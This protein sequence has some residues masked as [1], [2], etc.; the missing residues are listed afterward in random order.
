MILYLFLVSSRVHHDKNW[1]RPKNRSAHVKTTRLD[2]TVVDRVLSA[3]HHKVAK[4]ESRL[5]Q[6]TKEL[7]KEREENRTL[8]LIQHRQEKKLEQVIGEEAELP[9]L[10]VKHTAEVK[11]L[12]ERVRKLQDTSYHKDERL[13]E[14]DKVILKLKDRCKYYKELCEKEELTEKAQLEK[15]LLK[16]EDNLKKRD[17]E[18]SVSFF[19][20]LYCQVNMKVERVPEEPSMASMPIFLRNAHLICVLVRD[21]N[22]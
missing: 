3:N 15:N 16:A 22:C 1:R 21:T 20:I 14:Q 18:I 12:R 4:L 19:L 5:S 10:L 8:R 7:T 13:G 17:E 9:Q 11:S 2:H 6:L